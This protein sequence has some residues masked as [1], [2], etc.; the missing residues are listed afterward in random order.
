MKKYLVLNG[1]NL[2]LLGQREPG[3]YGKDSLKTLMARM[4]AAARKHGVAIG[5]FQSNH[6]GALI[7]KLHAAGDEGFAGII[8]NP[9]AFTHYS[10]ALRDAISAIRLPVI[11]VHISNIHAREEFRHHSVTAAV[12]QGQIAG[13]GLYGYELA[14]MALLEAEKGEEER[15]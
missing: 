12:A 3:T 6:E 9:G 4:E 10:Y 14:L 7:D 8:F 2:N 5:F 15:C 13:F 11:E 1:P